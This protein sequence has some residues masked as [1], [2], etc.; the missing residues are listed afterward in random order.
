MASKQTKEPREKSTGEWQAAGCKKK[1]Q[2]NKWTFLANQ[3]YN[4]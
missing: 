2:S 4:V 1:N 3:I